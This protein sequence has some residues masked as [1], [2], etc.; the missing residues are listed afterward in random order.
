MAEKKGMFEAMRMGV[1]SEEEVAIKALFPTTD[2]F[3]MHQMITELQPRAV[4]PWSILGVFREVYKS[5]VLRVFQEQ[6]NMDKISQERKGRLELSEVVA[7]ARSKREE[8]E[9]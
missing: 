1:E 7:R 2:K 6:Y 8:E 9:E 5:K 4:V 3:K